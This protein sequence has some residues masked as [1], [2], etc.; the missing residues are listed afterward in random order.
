MKNLI[1][2]NIIRY[3]EQNIGAFHEKRL[4]KLNKLKLRTVLNRKNPYL[5]K[6]KNVRTSEEIVKGLLDASL[7]SS[8]ETIF[9]DWL[10]GLAIFVNGKVY[11]VTEIRN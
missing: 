8:E 11:G 5:F 1:L 4:Q 6:A 7:S 3:V 10:E 2:K 9:G